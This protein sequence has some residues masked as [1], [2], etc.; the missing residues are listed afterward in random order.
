MLLC[1]NAHRNPLHVSD[2]YWFGLYKLTATRKGDTEWYDGNPSP[3]R[4]WVDGEPNEWT[5]CIRYTKEGFKD[6]ECWRLFH[7][8]CKKP[9]GN[10]VV[11]DLDT[12][13][14]HSVSL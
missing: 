11:I 4:D 10:L 7:Y 8:T 5:V 6:R 2:G 3:Y 14:F 1:N 13:S 12:V 9:A